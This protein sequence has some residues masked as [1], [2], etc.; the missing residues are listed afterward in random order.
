MRDSILSCWSR[1]SIGIEE[2]RRKRARNMRSRE[3][4]Q[5]EKNKAEDEG[6]R[7]TIKTCWTGRNVLKTSENMKKQED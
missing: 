3:T 5:G 1:M 4:E 2:K 6:E 7:Q